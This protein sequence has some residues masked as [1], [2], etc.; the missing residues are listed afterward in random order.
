MDTG[1]GH[2]WISLDS[3]TQILSHRR[4]YILGHSRIIWVS[5][6]YTD[7]QSRGLVMG[8]HPRI[9]WDSLGFLVY[10]DTQSQGVGHGCTSSDSPG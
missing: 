9:V 4:V 3:H 10:M 1:V 2:G 5:L 7:T 6:V 8:V